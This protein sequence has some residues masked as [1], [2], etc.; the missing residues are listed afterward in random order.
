MRAEDRAALEDALAVAH[1]PTLVVAMAQITGDASLLKDEWRPTYEM[2]PRGEPILSE[3]AQDGIRAKAREVIG[4][5]LSGDLN[6][7]PPPSP[8]VVRQMM[9]FIAGQEIPAHYVDFLMDEL[10]IEGASTK[11]PRWDSPRLQEAAKGMRAIVIGAGMSGILAGIRLSQAGVPFTIIEKNAD[12][13]GTWLENTYPGCRV[14]SSNHMYSYSFEPNHQWPQHFSTQPVLLD[15]FRGVADRYD[16]RK[17]IRF[18][19]TCE[20]CVWDEARQ[21]WRVLV[22]TK[23]GRGETLEANAVIAAVGQLN[24]P[25]LPDIEGR[26]SFKGPAFH[27]ARWRDDVDLAGKRVAVI[28]TGASAFQ[29]VPEIVDRAKS[30]TIFQR[31]P[32]WFFPNP[33]YHADVPEG[34]KWLLETVPSFDKWYRFSLFWSA[35]EGLLEAVRAEPGWNGPP[36]A[37]GVVNDQYRQLLEAAIEM[38]VG[39]NRAL[40]QKVIPNYPLGGKRGLVDNGTWINALQKPNVEIVTAK[41]TQINENGLKTEDGVQHDADVI[42]YGTGF[43]A[44]KFL[45]PMRIK[46]RGGRD[47]HEQWAGDP[48]AYLGMTVPGFPN[49]FMIYGPNTNIVINGSIIFFSE[50]SVRYIVESLK[51]LAETGASAMEVRRDVCDAFN[52]RVDEGNKQMAW[53]APQ[54]TSWYKNEAGRVTQNWPFSLVEYWQATITPDPKDFVLDTQGATRAA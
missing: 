8:A 33:N 35:A 45:M 22:T 18:E 39:E 4:A 1:L 28:G 15:Y 14:D 36:N 31:T 47:L 48:R 44:S 42:I 37:V 29:F 46:G 40:L 21:Q 2:F 5:L 27:S 11:D 53:G 34:M 51:L 19:T 13:G 9:D 20:E 10:A 32:P 50:C 52:A 43:H 54:V 3:A 30:I 38:Q 24:R 12:V 7:A 49:F 26:D 25:R 17:N 41:L 6:P 23:D 16:L